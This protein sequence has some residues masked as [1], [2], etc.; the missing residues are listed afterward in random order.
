MDRD[1]D[2]TSASST[3]A[4]HG[5]Q[6]PAFTELYEELRHIAAAYLR[7]ERSGHTLQ[8]TALVH[9]AYLRLAN[10]HRIEWTNRPLVLG[11]AAGIMRKILVSHA[12]RRNAL[13]RIQPSIEIEIG[14]G[15]ESSACDMLTLHDLLTRLEQSHSSAAK[16]IELRFFG[17]LTEEESAEF[18]RISRATV[19]RQ[20]SLGRAW[21]LRELGGTRPG[22][23]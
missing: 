18:L 19:Q 6:D 7:T 8:P 13:K 9:E 4:V 3:A 14:I 11:L 23:R 5:S 2:S 10:L 20:Y 15:P 16:V 1:G 17:G 21:L 12:R 22:S